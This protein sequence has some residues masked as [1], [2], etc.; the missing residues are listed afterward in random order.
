[1]R[2]GQTA[3]QDPTAGDSTTSRS[4]GSPLLGCAII[5]VLA[6]CLFSGGWLIV[7]HFT[8][9]AGKATTNDCLADD[10]GADP[11]YRRVDCDAKA[12]KYRVLQIAGWSV[13]GPNPCVEVAGASH[14]YEQY[15]DG[16]NKTICIG[17]KDAD[18]ATAA[19]AAKVGDCLLVSR[20]RDAL[21]TDCGDR[22]ANFTVLRR[23]LDASV[24]GLSVPGSQSDG[25]CAS[26]PGT[27]TTYGLQW[28]AVGPPV[29]TMHVIGQHYDLL[30]CLKRVNEPPPA[31]ATGPVN[32]RYLTPSGV[33]AAVNAVDGSRFQSAQI[34]ATTA[35]AP[36]TYVLLGGG[37][38]DVV[39]IEM[40]G[41]M[42]WP[43]A[44]HTE[45]V[46]D[47]VKAAWQADPL[48]LGI[49]TLSVQRTSGRLEIGVKAGD[50]ADVRGIAES[51]YRAAA[52]HVP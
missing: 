35:D 20:D 45:L 48:G 4:S 14:S 41:E 3:A 26:V 36:C 12:A 17:D 31:V 44:D 11:P 21:R 38:R 8:A 18:P 34:T 24:G 10:K 37:R 7:R 5:I 22:R 32:C 19:N 39:T 25:P 13:S 40:T 16:A 33:L 9:G 50:G 47:G 51:V 2:K 15:G 28:R 52:P 43:P 27:V 49:G 29:S 6:A 1:M 30:L 42:Q 46:I 23:L